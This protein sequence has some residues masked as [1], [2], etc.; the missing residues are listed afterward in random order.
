M[1]NI[2]VVFVNIEDIVEGEESFLAEM[3]ANML[4]GIEVYIL[5]YSSTF[6]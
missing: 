4:Q 1:P 5:C 3:K 6:N 2:E